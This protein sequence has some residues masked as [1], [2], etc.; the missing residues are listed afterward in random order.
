[1]PDY[2]VIIVGGRPAGASLAAR[3]GQQNI[4]TLIVEKATFPS[5]PPV[6]TPFILP[7]AMELLDEIG[8]DE[9]QYARNTPR[10][11]RSVLEFKNYFRV[12]L[13][14]A[15]RGGRNYIYTA[16][17]SRF[18]TAL[19]RH[20]SQYPTVTALENF[21]VRDLLKDE[22][23]RVIGIVGQ[24]AQKHTQSFTTDCVV[25]ADGRYSTVAQKVDAKII[26]QRTDL[27]ST[28]Y[29]AYWKNV[30]D[31]DEQGDTLPHIHTSGDGFSYIFM[32]T[33]DGLVA[34][35]AQGQSDLY[36]ALPGTIHEKYH[37]LLV[38]HPYIWRRLANA[39]QVS[40]LSGMKRMGN[41]FRQA[42]GQGWALVGDAYHQKDS[43]DA[44]GVY[45]ALVG[46]KYLAEAIGTWKKGQKTQQEALHDYGKR[47][48]EHLKPMFD[49]TM[50][51]VKREIYDIPPPFVAKH[52]LRWIISSRAYAYRFSNLLN[53]NIDPNNWLMPPAMLKM[54][55]TGLGGDLKRIITRRPNPFK[56]PDVAD[57]PQ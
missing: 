42:S 26:E 30:A 4:K 52:I 50:G 5:A 38:A 28:I 27:D 25:G 37:K 43:I 29:Y 54:M 47:I 31:Y 6:S 40:E 33:A 44:Q 35:V 39:E 36:E 53:R 13:P 24:G 45:D 11:Y 57:M 46:A 32:P 15:A 16:E 3:L 22:N 10:M 12:F 17:R 23:G 51:R 18:D 1:M 7:H 41:L 56:L 8:A 48:Y 34:V 55:A 9:G 20:L 49:S 2:D 21:S 14:L 19:W